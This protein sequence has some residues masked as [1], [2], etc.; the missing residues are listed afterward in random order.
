MPNYRL[1][2]NDDWFY[3]SGDYDILSLKDALT[4][5]VHNG[6][7]FVDVFAPLSSQISLLITKHSRVKFETLTTPDPS[8]LVEPTIGPS[9]MDADYWLD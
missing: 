1:T 6:G 7:G 8:D 4:A 3:L 9:F 2:I 5:A